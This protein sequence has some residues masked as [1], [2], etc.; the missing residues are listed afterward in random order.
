MR[1]KKPTPKPNEPGDIK[2]KIKYALF[3]TKMTDGSIIWLEKYKKT[4]ENMI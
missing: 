3:P 1:L 2:V 4:F